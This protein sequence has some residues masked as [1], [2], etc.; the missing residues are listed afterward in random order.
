[1]K[2]FVTSLFLIAS[3]AIG[4]F[5]Q[6][7]V[8]IPGDADRPDATILALAK[9]DVDVAIDNNRA[10]VRIVQI[11][12]N[13]TKNTLEGQYVF[14]LPGAA[15]VSDFA[16][17]ENTQRIPGV[18]LEKRRAN[19][20]YESIKNQQI[21]PG[22]LQ[23]TDDEDAESG[24][25]A[26]IFPIDAFGTKRLELE[27][28]EDLSVND[29]VSRI[30][31]PL[32]PNAGESQ[33]VRSFS[34]RVHVAS[35]HPIAPESAG[36]GAFPLTLNTVSANEFTGEFGA[37]NFELS[38]DFEFGY[39]TEVGADELGVVAYRA[40]ERITAFDLRDPRSA[41]TNANGYFQAQAIFAKR[42]QTPRPPKRLVVALDTSLSMYGE[43]IRQGVEALDFFLHSLRPEDQ[44]SLML[45]NDETT[46]FGRKP[47][48]AT[49]DSVESALKFVK[50]AT[51][52]GGTNL[53]KA[54]RSARDEANKFGGGAVEIVMITDANPTRETAK[55]KEIAGIFKDSPFRFS[56]F[57]LGESANTELLETLAAN[58]SGMVESAR[59]TEDIAVKL[60]SFFA[61]I[62]APR[63][64]DVALQEDQNLYDVYESSPGSF[65]GAD[66]RFVGRYRRP[67][68]QIFRLTTGNGI[69]LERTLD[70]PELD[71]S[72]GFLPR[73]WA[74]ARINALLRVINENGE[75]EELINEII[76]LSEKYK[77]VTPYT[78][79]L[80]APRAL[81]RPRLIQPGDPVIRVR[82]DESITGVT[83]VLP[84]GETLRLEFDTTEKL[85]ETR[86]LAPEWMTDGTYKCRLILTDRN[87]NAYEESKSFVID[88]RAPKVKIDIENRAYRAGETVEVRVRSDRDTA[89]LTARLFG[90]E[91][92]RLFWSNEKKANV[93][94][95][96]IGE[97][98]APGRY[99]LSVSAADFAHNQTTEDISIEVTGL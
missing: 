70:L 77:I 90:S 93:G 44:F 20:L 82:T 69:A 66:V 78:A 81:L 8:L 22:I 87:G 21:D 88:S 4:D 54:V 46:A 37:E 86:F 34:L 7:G 23:T 24:F 38:N 35:A 2:R 33:S 9:M 25:R 75:S 51:L 30:T 97:S 19:A 28:T 17:W 12:E 55:Q 27:Y 48:A 13:K 52:G 71:E 80:A 67:Q 76:S 1:M 10:T 15:A 74:Q 94:L 79:F 36:G 73:L 91:P 64:T 26:K 53:A 11:F 89:R 6:S 58:S 40:P 14:A 31:I 57:A 61:R 42:P 16:V 62:G 65:F 43:K 95:L 49:P 29:L 68:P 47:V 45:F 39:R 59:E 98:L 56:A 85:W 5:A 72:H 96:K 18:M 83:A 3:L 32:K 99:T 84:F 63:V 41:Q 92:V 60:A 50:A